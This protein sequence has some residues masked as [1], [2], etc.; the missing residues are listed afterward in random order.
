VSAVRVAAVSD[1]PDEGA[2]RVEV[3]ELPICLA[4][5]GGELFAVGD[6]CSH[7]EV[8]LSEGGVEDGA[9]EC[10][11]HG[12]QFDLRTGKPLGLPANRP[13]PTYRVT[14]EDDAVLV[15]VEQSA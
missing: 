9:V 14:V 5:S 6:V 8:S 10:W 12:S 13:V 2:I 3:G 11:L 1:V 15:D 4:R 7:A